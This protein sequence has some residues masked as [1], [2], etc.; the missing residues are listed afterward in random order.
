MKNIRD[1]I[2]FKLHLTHD[3]LYNNMKQIISRVAH[4]SFQNEFESCWE[5]YNINQNIFISMYKINYII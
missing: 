4:T 1:G 3:L 5:P 2:E